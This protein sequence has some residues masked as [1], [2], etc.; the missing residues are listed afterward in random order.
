MLLLSA[1]QSRARVRGAGPNARG[2]SRI[3]GG[4]RSESKVRACDASVQEA[5][6][7]AQLGVLV[8]DIFQHF[9]IKAPAQRVFEAV[10]TPAGLDAWWTLNSSR[11]SDEGAEYM[12]GFGPG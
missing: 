9:P 3:S 2:A 5:A 7:E 8:A 1:L 4:D 10:S 6:R 12:L 11:G